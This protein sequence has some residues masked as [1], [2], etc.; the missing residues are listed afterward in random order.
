MV[1]SL[2]LQNDNDNIFMKTGQNYWWFN[3]QIN[4][5][6][7]Y[8][9]YIGNKC[10]I[11]HVPL[12][13]SFVKSSQ[14]KRG[15]WSGTCDSW[16]TQ[17]HMVWRSSCF[18]ETV[19]FSHANSRSRSRS[20][21]WGVGGRGGRE[22]WEGRQGQGYTILFHLLRSSRTLNSRV[23]G[24]GSPS[25]FCTRQHRSLQ[26]PLRRKVENRFYIKV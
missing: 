3:L 13:M 24:T 20:C 17:I 1:P 16:T 8:M 6:L 21:S 14:V 23:H 26:S 10:T 7:L 15:H 18:Q 5:S 9:E 25:L 12:I 2:R 19:R 22:G 4:I 11:V